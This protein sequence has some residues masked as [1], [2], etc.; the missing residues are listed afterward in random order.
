MCLLFVLF[1]GN[2]NFFI[3]QK[4]IRHGDS[5][6]LCGQEK[7]MNNFCFARL[8]QGPLLNL[9]PF[10]ELEYVNKATTLCIIYEV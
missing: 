9:E 4:L 7:E 3:V 1:A 2:E 8:S 5:D 6:Q 10:E